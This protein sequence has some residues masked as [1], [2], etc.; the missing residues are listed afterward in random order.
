MRVVWL[1]GAI[2]IQE[3]EYPHAARCMSFGASGM[4]LHEIKTILDV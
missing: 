2:P 4:L 1:V 3:I